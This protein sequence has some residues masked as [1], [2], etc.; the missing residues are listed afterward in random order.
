VRVDDAE[1]GGE[2]EAGNGGKAYEAIGGAARS[3]S[4]AGQL[5]RT[6]VHVGEDAGLT[7]KRIEMRCE[8]ALGPFF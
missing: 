2:I 8:V 4:G 3:S 6:V 1:T 5:S 7:A